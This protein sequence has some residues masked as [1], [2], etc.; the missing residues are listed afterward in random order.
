MSYTIEAEVNQEWFNILDIIT[1][2]QE[3]FVWKKVDIDTEG[4]E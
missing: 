2:H 1:R 4:N 3:G